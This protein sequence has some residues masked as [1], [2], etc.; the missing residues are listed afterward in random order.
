MKAVLREN[1][2]KY[3][4]VDGNIGPLSF[5]F[6]NPCLSQV[7]LLLEPVRQHFQKDRPQIDAVPED[8]NKRMVSWM[9]VPVEG[10]FNGLFAGFKIRWSGDLAIPLNKTAFKRPYQTT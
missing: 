2:G 4:K 10:L 1:I 7:N 9:E 3:R 8:F 5:P 6:W